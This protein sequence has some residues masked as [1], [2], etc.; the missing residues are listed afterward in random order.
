MLIACEVGVRQ[1]A[2]AMSGIS[3]RTA[4]RIMTKILTDEIRIGSLF[5]VVVK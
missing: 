3:E 1:V 5:G 2:D 4:R